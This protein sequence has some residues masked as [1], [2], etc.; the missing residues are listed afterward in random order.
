MNKPW[1]FKKPGQIIKLINFGQLDTSFSRKAKTGLP[2]A[3]VRIKVIDDH[4]N[5][6]ARDEKT[7]SE[8]IV[9]GNQAIWL[10]SIKRAI[11]QLWN[12]KKISGW[13]QSAK[14]CR[15]PFWFS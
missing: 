11:S 6:V 10:Q 9:R 7:I 1:S 3:G 13:I 14:I 4:G 5:D 2:L 12:A 15:I 8:I